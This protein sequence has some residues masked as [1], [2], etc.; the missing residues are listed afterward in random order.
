MSAGH[1]FRP[2][3]TRACFCPPTKLSA[4]ENSGASSRVMLTF[5]YLSVSIGDPRERWGYAINATFLGP[6]EGK[7]G[8]SHFG[9]WLLLLGTPGRQGLGSQVCFCP[10]V[11]TPEK[12]EVM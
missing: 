8:C 2:L 4:P 5:L 12:V 1:F 11:G 3:P 10:Y 7:G 6:R 9:F